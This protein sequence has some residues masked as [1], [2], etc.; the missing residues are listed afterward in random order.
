MNA[1]ILREARRLASRPYQIQ[2]VP[3]EYSDGAPTY[4]ARIPEMPG[5]VSHGDTIAEALEWI[6]LA[7]IDYIYSLL[8]DGVPVPQPRH[9]NSEEGVLM[10]IVDFDEESAN[11]ETY[12][13][14]KS[15]LQLPALPTGPH[16]YNLP[17]AR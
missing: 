15:K 14:S 13:F 7:K 10:Q 12:T 3:D 4:F 17:L 9:E 2:I 6:E 5:C 16:C 11:Q 8:E 1:E